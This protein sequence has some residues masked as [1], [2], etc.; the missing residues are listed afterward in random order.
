MR[1]R[2]VIP[3]SVL[4][5]PPTA[6]VAPNS[7]FGEILDWL[8]APLLLLWPISIVATNHVANHIAN[9]PYDQQLADDVVAVS[10][11]VRQEGGRV[12]VNLPLS[13]RTLLRTDDVDSMYFQVAVVQGK[14]LS[15]DTELPIPAAEDGY[16]FGKVMYRDER[17]EG[18]SI[19]LAYLFIAPVGG[20][21]PI[22][23]QVGETRHKRESL[24]SNIISGVLL[25]Q[26]AIIPLAVILV[27]L[28]LT[29]GIAPLRLLRA[30]IQRRS[31]GDLSPLSVERM[32]DEVRPLVEAFNEMMARLEANLQAQ[33]RFIADAAHQMRTP[34]TGL[35]M[36][37]E[38]AMTE[39]DPVRMREGLALIAQ[40]AERATHLIS[41]L[42]ALA[43]TEAS[44]AQGNLEAV[45]LTS[46]AQGVTQEWVERALSKRID[47][48][49]EAPE[50][51][52][53]IDGVPLL[54]RELLSNLIDNAVKYTPAGGCVTV[55]LAVTSNAI[56]E[57]EDN[58]IGIPVEDRAR[59]FERFYRVLGTDT[60]GSGL[61]LPIAA[62][63]AELHGG[64]IEL[65]TAGGGQGS[66]FRIQFP[67]RRE[68]MAAPPSA[69]EN[70]LPYTSFPVGL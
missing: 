35:R 61:G 36:Q 43:R 70:K 38:L 12:V 63:I 9:Q 34:L 37:T 57:I 50:A 31:Q 49:F 69:F 28:G 58:G 33:Q 13:A 20:R 42:L 60:D 17:M 8:L 19:R 32:P 62:E 56:L 3:R 6:D 40:S 44:L 5:K 66:L 64:K 23:V 27:W 39:S 55:R 7:L 26:F 15:G 4:I 2:R 24:A 10:R 51:P 21:K 65:S 67:R 16:E 53:F 54:L 22:L 47:L 30:R 25:P 59:V 1:G 68:A 11:L 14:I 52:L 46:L 48:G 18:D 29:R 45:D 41:Q